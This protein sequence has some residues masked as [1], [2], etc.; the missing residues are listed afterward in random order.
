MKLNVRRVV[1][2]DG[3]SVSITVD[4]PP[5]ARM[6]IAEQLIA[7]IAAMDGTGTLAVRVNDAEYTVHYDQREATG[8]NGQPVRG[9]FTGDYEVVH[10]GRVIERMHVS[11]HGS[12]GY[13]NSYA[14]GHSASTVAAMIAKHAVARSTAAS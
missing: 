13:G 7:P 11:P 3:R 12:S 6:T 9:D 8:D 5:E 1:D 2:D 10:D 14:K 4:G